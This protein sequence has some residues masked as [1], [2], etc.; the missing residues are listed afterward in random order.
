MI[1]KVSLLAIYLSFVA[2]G[3]VAQSPEF[4]QVHEMD[5]VKA[6]RA[7][8][9][10]EQVRVTSNPLAVQPCKYLGNVRSLGHATRSTFDLQFKTVLL[11]GDTVFSTNLRPGREIIGDA[12]VCADTPVVVTGRPISIEVSQLRD[13]GLLKELDLKTHTARVN[14]AQWKILPQNKREAIARTLALECDVDGTGRQ[15]VD[16]F[17]SGTGVQVG[18]L[19]PK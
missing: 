12:Y 19:V 9:K 7:S 8:E 5:P 10:A 15:W 16:I 1:Q 4:K 17:D 14:G 2:C 6:M 3:H 11:G 13:S 18:R